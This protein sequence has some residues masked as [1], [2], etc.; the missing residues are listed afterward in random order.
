MAYTL[1]ILGPKYQ[2]QQDDRGN[3]ISES[4]PFRYKMI[5]TYGSEGSESEEGL[6]RSSDSSDR[7]FL[8][9]TIN[10]LMTLVLNYLDIENICHID[11]AVSNA[12]ERHICS[13]VV[14]PS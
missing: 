8:F 12:V 10:D 3:C 9:S 13:S 7:S 14:I 6:C 5:A 1:N 4:G 11:V 2:T